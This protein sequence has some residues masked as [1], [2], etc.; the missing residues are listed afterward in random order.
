MVLISW[1]PDPESNTL[2]L[3]SVTKYQFEMLDVFS[4]QVLAREFPRLRMPLFGYSADSANE[5]DFYPIDWGAK[6]EN[7]VAFGFTGSCEHDHSD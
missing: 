1:T 3:Q 5:F 7:A 2:R 6:V 4:P